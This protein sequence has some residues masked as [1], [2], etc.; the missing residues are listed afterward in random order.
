VCP[1]LLRTHFLS[2]VYAFLELR[3]EFQL[4]G[5]SVRCFK[6]LA[7]FFFLLNQVETESA[8]G[9]MLFK[10]RAFDGHAADGALLFGVV[11]VEILLAVYAGLVGEIVGLAAFWTA[12]GS[13]VRFFL[14][15]LLFVV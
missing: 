6:L 3:L 10:E 4:H 9:F 15:L 8:A 11:L 12:D 2:A 7:F 14:V 1:H 5:E 13:L